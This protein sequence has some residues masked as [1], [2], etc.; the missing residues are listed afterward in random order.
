MIECL[1][2]MMFYNVTTDCEVETPLEADLRVNRMSAWYG[3]SVTYSCTN[4]QQLAGSKYR[5]CGPRGEWVT[6]SPTCQGKTKLCMA[7][8]KQGLFAAVF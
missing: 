5:K 3:Q 1:F 2:Y 4:G 7:A 8:V 6:P